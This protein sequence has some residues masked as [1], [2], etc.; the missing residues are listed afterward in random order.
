M[1]RE[2]GRTTIVRFLAQR[3]KLKEYRMTA[4][5]NNKNQYQTAI[6]TGASRGIGKSIALRLASSGYRLFLLGR[7]TAA[8]DAV[9]DACASEAHYLAGDI[10]DAAYLDEA[11]A[12]AQRTLGSIDGLIN[13]AGTA[14]VGAVYET[15]A[16]DWQTVFDVNF[17]AAVHLT[18]AVLPTMMAR[19]T[20]VIVNISSISGRVATAE[21]AIYCATKF[22]L[23]GFGVSLFEDVRDFDIKVTTIL[24]GY[25]ETAL[26][27]RRGLNDK[28]M[29]DPTDIADA[30]EYVFNTSPRA[31]PTEIV[32]RPQQ[33]P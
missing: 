9:V 6:V 30:V 21:N 5:V 8:L 23:N 24:P 27:A 22:A 26:T 2:G 10:R 11:V 7:D 32:I 31:C 12:Q 4:R 3:D 19:K 20:G 13:N 15:E 17:N 16:S 29:I 14:H 28:R 1:W 18:R 25:V 33:R